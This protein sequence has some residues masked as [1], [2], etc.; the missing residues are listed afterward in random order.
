MEQEIETTL[1]ASPN[2]CGYL[3]ADQNGLLIAGA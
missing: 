1:S 2:V 3:C